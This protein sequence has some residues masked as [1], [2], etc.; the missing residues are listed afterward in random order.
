MRLVGV[1]F[2]GEALADGAHVPVVQDEHLIDDFEGL[3]AVNAIEMIHFGDYALGIPHA[4]AVGS[5]GRVDAAEG[6]LIRAAQRGVDGGIGLARGEISEALPVVRAVLGHGEQMPGVAVQVGVEIFDQGRG[7]VETDLFAIAPR[8]PFDF[9]EIF[10]PNGRPTG[11]K[12]PEKLVDGNGSFAGAGEIDGFF[13]E[14]LLGKGGHMSPHNDNGDMRSVLLD[15]AADGSGAGHLLG[16]SGGLMAE[17]NHADQAGV[18]CGHLA[19]DGFG[20]FMF[21]LGIEDGDRVAAVG[22]I[23]GDQAAPEGRF[24]GTQF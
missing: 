4:V 12:R 22:D 5:K 3:H 2:G 9:A 11:G 13:A 16:G 14:G 23:T 15:G 21:G 10:R 7:G 24:D 20:A 19:G 6:A 1:G 18:K 8:Q 17:D